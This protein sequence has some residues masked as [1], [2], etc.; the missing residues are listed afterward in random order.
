MLGR[1]VTGRAEYQR[2]AIHPSKAA[3]AFKVA[4]DVRKFELDLYWKRA[5]YFW[6]FIGFAF[7]GYFAVA[8]Q[9]STRSGILLAIGSIG[10]VFSFAW[11]LANRGS[12]FWVA[13]WERHVDYLEDEQV[14]RLF[15][16]YI[17][18]PQGIRDMLMLHKAY[19]FSVG[20]VNQIL[21][22]YVTAIWLV[23]VW[24]EYF[25][26]CHG[27]T[28]AIGQAAGQVAM[29]LSADAAVFL[30]MFARTDFQGRSGMTFRIRGVPD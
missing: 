7:T 28:P 6:T 30:L 11:F 9:S 23:I 3:E 26:I 1:K 17:D 24:K 16:T 19:P 13:N 4:T 29:V 5:L 10:M 18:K 25:S 20:K 2:Y 15:K 22:L 8:S 27:P 12:K 14:G 21:N